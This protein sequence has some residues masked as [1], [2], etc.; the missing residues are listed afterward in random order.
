MAHGMVLR[1]KMLCLARHM[2]GLQWM[3]LVIVPSICSPSLHVSL[4]ACA[5]SLTSQKAAVIV[6][7]NILW[8]QAEYDGN[9]YQ[10]NPV[11]SAFT[12][13]REIFVGEGTSFMLAGV[14]STMTL[15]TLPLHMLILFPKSMTAC[16]IGREFIFRLAV[17]APL[18]GLHLAFAL[19]SGQLV[20][21]IC[22][23]HMGP[24]SPAW[25]TSSRAVVVMVSCGSLC[26]QAAQ[27]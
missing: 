2:A 10:T 20:M 7:M 3:L 4:S 18:R 22:W 14:V 17:L 13:R 27:P 21:G 6:V 9:A 11:Q 24:L 1:L 15:V 25:S 16:F 5:R 19:L 23:W 12:R 26:L 8:L